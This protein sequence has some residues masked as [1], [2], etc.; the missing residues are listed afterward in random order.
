MCGACEVA[1]VY[2]CI[3]WCINFFMSVQS[4]VLQDVDCGLQTK[5]CVDCVIVVSGDAS[6]IFPTNVRI[7]L[8]ALRHLS[9]CWCV[10]SMWLSM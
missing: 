9:R 3:V 8:N 6:C 7:V 5:K 4:A 1:R 10:V 2:D